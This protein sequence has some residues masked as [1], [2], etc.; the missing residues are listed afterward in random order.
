LNSLDIG[1]KKIVKN[2]A[3]ITGGTG[4]LGRNLTKNL[5]DKGWEVNLVVR[6]LSNLNTYGSYL[7][8]A[9]TH[10]YDG[11]LNSLIKILNANRPAVVFH[12]A[13]KVVSH[14]KFD[15]INDI[16]KSNIL[17]GSQLL[18]A[19]RICNLKKI[20]NTGTFWQYYD[21]VEYNPVSLYA[22]SK[23]AFEDI[24][25]Y[26]AYA[27]NFEVI[28]LTLFDNYGPDDTRPK[29]FPM[30]NKSALSKELVKMSAGEQYI[31]IVYIDDVVE[32]YKAAGLILLSGVDLNYKNYVVSSFEPIK[33]RDLVEIY[34]EL[35]PIKPNILWGARPYRDREVMFPWSAGTHLPGWRPKTGLREGMKRIVP[36]LNSQVKVKH[37]EK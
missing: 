21:G 3:L 24:L 6:D 22:A 27:E 16:Y 8:G 10:I 28:T 14:H 19:M 5:L 11:D 7:K 12:L 15:N 13:A 18:E 1:R 29:L 17:F 35:A 4:Y 9:R 20:V 37:G 2:I 30:L 31:D 34:L 32:A 25:K 36:H 33:L 26:Y 23:Q